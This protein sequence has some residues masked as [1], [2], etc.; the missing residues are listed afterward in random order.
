LASLVLPDWLEEL[1]FFGTAPH[2]GHAEI[3]NQLILSVQNW[4]LVRLSLGYAILPAEEHLNPQGGENLMTPWCLQCGEL[5]E[6]RATGVDE[7]GEAASELHHVKQETV[8]PATT[9]PPIPIPEK[10]K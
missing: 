10:K 2:P 9:T 5:G 1:A 6:P 3:A 4:Y 7:D 8:Q